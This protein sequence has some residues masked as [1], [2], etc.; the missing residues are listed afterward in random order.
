MEDV[1]KGTIAMY[2]DIA[3][4]WAHLAGLRL[5]R[6][7][8]R[9]GLT[10]RVHFDMR[11][12]PLELVNERPT[13]KRILDEEIPVAGALEPSAEWQVWQ[14]ESHE[15]PVTTLLPLEAVA[16]ARELG[17]DAHERLAFG[18]RHA[19]FAQSRCVSLRHEVLSVARDE[20][21]DT[22]ALA[23]A[24]DNG[25]ARRVVLDQFHDHV[26]GPVKGS[27][28]LFLPDGS[29]VHNPGIDMHWEGEP[30]V[31]F[32]VVDNDDESVYE[33]ILTRVAA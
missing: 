32:P 8:A 29:D 33:D 30:G 5:M 17:Q 6:W 3:C 15:W 27:P 13:P 25:R 24:L 10:D 26:D 20:G 4:P 22:W 21:I 7:R 19:L 16:A 28:H 11:A 1:P 14:R 12:F 2:G 18:L 23:R 31:G 9:L